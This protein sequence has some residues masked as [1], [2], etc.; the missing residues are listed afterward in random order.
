MSAQSTVIVVA[1]GIE[2][3]DLD[4]V[5]TST[6]VIIVH[7]D[8][9]LAEAACAHPSVTHLRPAANLGFGPGVN[10]AL[11]Q[12][13]T[14]R[15]ILCN[16]DTL[17]TPA[18]FDALDRVGP[19]TIGAI[20][21]VEADGV[22][23]AVVNPYWSVPAFLATAWRLGRFVPRRGRLLRLVAPL[24]GRYGSAHNEALEHRAGEWPILDRWVAGAVLSLPT[25]ALRAVGG[26][27]ED[28]F[29]YFE[30][31]D[32]QQRL[33]KARPELTIKLMATE[34]AFH[35]VGGTVV[36]RADAELVARHR[37]RSARIYASRQHGAAW[38]VAQRLVEMGVS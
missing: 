37:R 4:W 14:P 16:P 6:P 15:V 10:L 11:L 9:R 36:S 30:D 24:L 32:L 7:N 34:P 33:A 29:L 38:R 21:L 25:A 35:A 12:V 18:H 28:Y 20:P 31:A 5:P 17:L 1:Y 22:P 8:D 19:N 2:T 26:F 23:N 27:D 13:T 3:L